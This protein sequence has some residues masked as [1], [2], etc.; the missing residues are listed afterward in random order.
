[1]SF[2]GRKQNLPPTVWLGTSTLVCVAPEEENGGSWR[3]LGQ[4]PEVLMH[5]PA[6]NPLDRAMLVQL[7][8][9][10]PA[11]QLTTTPAELALG[12]SAEVGLR[13]RPGVLSE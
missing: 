2:A 8:G 6:K 5:I 4:W 9:G 10:G 1:M 13:R 11:C 3:R 7:C 12:A